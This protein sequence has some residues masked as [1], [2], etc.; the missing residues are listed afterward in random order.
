M[1]SSKT[2]TTVNQAIIERTQ[3]LNAQSAHQIIDLYENNF[4][5][6]N[7][8]NLPFHSLYDFID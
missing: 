7:I 3:R 6:Y 4:R 8:D 2:Q 1:I 5:R